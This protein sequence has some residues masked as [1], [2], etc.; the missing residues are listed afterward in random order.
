MHVTLS[1]SLE[2]E[3]RTALNVIP[4]LGLILHLTGVLYSTIQ[5]HKHWVCGLW[6]LSERAV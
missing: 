5:Y 6:T 3:Q 1:S 4:Y 2:G